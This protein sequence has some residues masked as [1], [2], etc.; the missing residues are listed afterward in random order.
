[1]K[2]YSEIHLEKKKIYL[3]CCLLRFSG[4]LSWNILINYKSAFQVLNV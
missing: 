2:I 3:L 1:M 4:K